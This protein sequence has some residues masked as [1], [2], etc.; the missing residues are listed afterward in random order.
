MIVY[1]AGPIRPKGNQ[2]M[3][4]NVNAAKA[5]ALE[6]W[7]AGY[8]VICPHANSDLPI[9]LADKECEPSIWLNG[10]LEIVARCDAV[11][12]LPGWETSA[13]AK[14]EIQFAEERKIPVYYYPDR[15]VSA[16]PNANR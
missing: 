13:G 6:L 14:G 9:E 1:L 16:Q 11:I 12:V 10:D 5:I 7:R 8:A 2:T 4:G 3:R 15:P